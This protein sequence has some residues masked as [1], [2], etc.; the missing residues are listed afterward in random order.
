RARRNAFRDSRPRLFTLLS[1]CVISPSR[2]EPACVDE[3][4]V[5][6]PLSGRRAERGARPA[7][8]GRAGPGTIAAASEPNASAWT[9]RSVPAIVHG[10]QAAAIDLLERRL[11]G[12]VDAFVKLG[13]ALELTRVGA[14]THGVRSE[15]DAAIERFRAGLLVEVEIG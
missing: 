8:A 10:V 2:H 5:A 9:V 1:R 11:R 4:A 13:A 7:A 15:L 3:P 14:P 6:R 12:L